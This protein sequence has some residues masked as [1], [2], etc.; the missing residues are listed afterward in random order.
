M[1]KIVFTQQNYGM[2]ITKQQLAAAWASNKKKREAM[3]PVK[4]C[5]HC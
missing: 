3:L 5:I 2:I 1:A 4:K